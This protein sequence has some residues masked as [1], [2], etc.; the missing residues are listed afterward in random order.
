MKGPNPI[1]II[2]PLCTALHS[3]TLPDVLIS[4]VELLDIK[5]ISTLFWTTTDLSAQTTSLMD[6]I[7]RHQFFVG[8]LF[9]NI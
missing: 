7:E 8:G 1:S 3:W 4:H 2:E 9:E 5:F 6:I